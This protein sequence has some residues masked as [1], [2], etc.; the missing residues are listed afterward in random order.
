MRGVKIKGRSSSS[1][2]EEGVN[3]ALNT[4][5]SPHENNTTAR[6]A[7]AAHLGTSEGPFIFERISLLSL[8]LETSFPT[9]P[10]V[11]VLHHVPT[12]VEFHLLERK[13][14]TNKNTSVWFH[15]GVLGEKRVTAGENMCYHIHQHRRSREFSP[16]GQMHR[17]LLYVVIFNSR[18]ACSRQQK[19]P[20]PAFPQTNAL[21]L[22][23]HEKPKGEVRREGNYIKLSVQ[24][25]KS[26][27]GEKLLH[28]Q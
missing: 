7:E 3:I 17:A 28:V 26:R 24:N 2:S 4:R 19:L 18:N 12:E 16:P 20:P 21:T 6:I 9:P 13:A 27:R 22:C 11:A 15:A 1:S 14:T 25:S 5:G 23:N 8:G 10:F